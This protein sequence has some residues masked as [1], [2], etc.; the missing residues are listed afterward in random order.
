MFTDVNCILLHSF[1]LVSCLLHLL[2][3]SCLCEISISTCFI[4]SADRYW[5]CVCVCVYVCVRECVCVCVRARAWMNVRQS[6][7]FRSTR[8]ADFMLWY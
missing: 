3:H 1:K 2:C 7:F 8:I 5:M 4:N 6:N